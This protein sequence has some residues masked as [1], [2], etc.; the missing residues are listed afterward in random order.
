M[1]SGSSR[2]CC[3]CSTGVGDKHILREALKSLGLPVAAARVKRAIQFGSCI[4]KL[5]NTRDWGSNRKANKQSA[6]QVRLAQLP[7]TIED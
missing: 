6:G 5:S 7:R 3:C 2:M 4:G 1:M